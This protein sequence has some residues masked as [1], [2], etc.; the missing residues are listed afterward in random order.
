MDFNA[1]I[2][3]MLIVMTLLGVVALF[4]FYVVTKAIEGIAHWW[5]RRD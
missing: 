2:I 3:G 4:I 5:I 1:I